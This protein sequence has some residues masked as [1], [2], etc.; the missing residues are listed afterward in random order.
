M[1][2]RYPENT[3]TADVAIEVYNVQSIEEL[4]NE[5]LR[6]MI[7][8]MSNPST[9][10]PVE[11]REF[12]IEAKEPERLV[13]DS[14]EE[15]IYLKDAET[16]IFHEISARV[17]EQENLIIATIRGRG[18]YTDIYSQEVGVDVKAVTWHQFTVKQEED[19]TWY[20]FIILDV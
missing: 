3:A 2:Y 6:A 15:L 20:A 10:K 19:G 13:Y 14:L 17:M 4:L 12:T 16:F 18:D 1:P 5:A 9:V 11:E 7:G 8:L